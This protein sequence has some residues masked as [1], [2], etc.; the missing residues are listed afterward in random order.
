MRGKDV[1]GGLKEDVF[2]QIRVYKELGLNFFK[3]SF[4]VLSSLVLYIPVLD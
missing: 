3:G 4:I 1:G 2:I